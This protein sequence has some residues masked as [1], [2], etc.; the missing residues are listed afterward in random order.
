MN[1]WN[2]IRYAKREGEN[3]AS[4]NGGEGGRLEVGV[5]MIS[6]IHRALLREHGGGNN[7]LERQDFEEEDEEEGQNGELD[8]HGLPVELHMDDYDDE[9]EA[10]GGAQKAAFIHADASEEEEGVENGEDEEDEDEEEVGIMEEEEEEEEGEEEDEGEEGEEVEEE[11]EESGRGKEDQQRNELAG[12]LPASAFLRGMDDN[13]EED[14]DSEDMEDHMIKSTDAVVLV[15]N[16][17]GRA[18]KRGQRGG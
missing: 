3:T 9:D 6:S 16:T 18:A 12:A 7:E 11:E 4:R 1:G 13:D 14:D 2:N 5:F 15:A 17:E 10:A 8:R